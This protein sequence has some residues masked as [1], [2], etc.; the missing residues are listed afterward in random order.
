VFWYYRSYFTVVSA[1]H[2][3]LVYQTPH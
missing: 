1:S 2:Q 3:I